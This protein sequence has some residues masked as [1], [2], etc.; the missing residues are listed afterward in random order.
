LVSHR[1]L[2]SVR[3]AI[4]KTVNNTEESYDD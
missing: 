2:I 3:L 1:G 4:I